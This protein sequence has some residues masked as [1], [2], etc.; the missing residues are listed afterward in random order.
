VLIKKEMPMKLKHYALLIILVFTMFVLSA[1]GNGRLKELQ[2]Q[3]NALDTQ[4]K[5]VNGQRDE[6]QQRL[7]DLQAQ[8]ETLT[9]ERDDFKKQLDAAA[10]ER[11]QSIKPPTLPEPSPAP[12]SELDDAQQAVE[13]ALQNQSPPATETP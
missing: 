9:A 7:D 13:D 3:V 4:V 8:L 12:S 1:C 10:L 6:L 11:A 2:T 5:I